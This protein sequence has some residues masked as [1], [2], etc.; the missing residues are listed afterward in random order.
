MRS[1]T[2]SGGKR[3]EDKKTRHWLAI[4]PKNFQGLAHSCSV[5]AFVFKQHF[6]EKIGKKSS[7]S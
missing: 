4:I 5:H 2:D 1:R 7:K 3:I 6:Y